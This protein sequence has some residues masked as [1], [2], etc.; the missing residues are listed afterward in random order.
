MAEPVD[1]EFFTAGLRLHYVEWGDPDRHTVVL[2]HGN[3]DQCRS[4]DFFAA[5]LFARQPFSYHV[6]ALDLRGHGDSDWSPPGQAYQ[7]ADFLRDVAELLRHLK[8]DSATFIGHSLGASIA[9][10]FAGCFPEKV[11]RL[12][13]I[14]ALG[15][16][17]RSD[18]DVPKLLARWLEDDGTTMEERMVYPALEEAAGAIEKRFPSIPPA[19]RGHMARYGTKAA[20]QGFIWKHDP[21]MRFPSY[22]TFSEAQIQ[23]FIRRIECPTLLVYGSE[24]G[25][26]KS[27]RAPRV[28]L[29]KN[30]RVVAIAGSG[31]HVPH[32]KPDELV[33]VVYPFLMD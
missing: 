12:V 19:A 5:A 1:R 33:K 7:H 26:I 18:E 3:R 14:E 17:A 8:K 27:P 9:L 6:A 2:V 20:E 29:F 11:K 22:S 28:S 25:F 13:L 23:A 32:E 16:Y 10:L 21:R 24:S 4:W 30:G 31:H 15:P